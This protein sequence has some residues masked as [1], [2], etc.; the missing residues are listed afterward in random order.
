MASNDLAKLRAEALRLHKR[1]SNRIS[2]EKARSGLNVSGTEMDPRRAPA[3]IRSMRSRDVDAHIRRMQTFITTPTPSYRAANGQAIPAP[4]WQA[5]KREESLQRRRANAELKRI[6]QLRTPGV[7]DASGRRQ[8]G[9]T[10]NDREANIAGQRMNSGAATNRP[11]I[12]LKRK[13][14]AIS[15]PEK[16][17]Q[18]TAAMQNRNS[19]EFKAERLK[20]SREQ[21]MEMLKTTG[22]PKHARMAEKLTDEQLNVLWNYT[23]F[24]DTL[25]R[26]YENAVELAKTDKPKERMRES[27]RATD[28]KNISELLGWARRIQP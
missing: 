3:K 15:S 16:L 5:Y 4:A 19:P 1:V 22:N 7:K 9:M 18:L 26:D 6:G 20:A 10:I 12:A 24:A 8:K 11:L 17:A 2:R 21:L 13:A 14:T 28:D 27:A 25:S 23:N